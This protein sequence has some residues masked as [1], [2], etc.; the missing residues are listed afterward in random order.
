VKGC[1]LNPGATFTQLSSTFTVKAGRLLVRKLPSQYRI[2]GDYRLLAIPD[3]IP[4][5][6]VKQE[7]PM[8]LLCEKVGIAGFSQGPQT[9]VW[10][11]FFCPCSVFVDGVHRNCPVVR[12]R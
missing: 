1:S 2:P 4:N 7:L 9:S 5:S 10:G 3:S 8:I 12:V 6:V 11:P